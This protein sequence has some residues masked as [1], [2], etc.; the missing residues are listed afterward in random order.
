MSDT[1][2]TGTFCWNELVTG[3]TEKAGEFYSKLLGWECVERDMGQFV[4][5][6]F[7]MGDTFAGGMMAIQKE[8]GEV[9]P[10]WMSYIL[11]DD[12]DAST[13][14]AEELGAKMCVTPMDIPNVGRFSTIIDPTGAAVS[15]FAPK[16]K[17]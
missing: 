6:E 8:W 10:H 13:K 16:K 4:Y 9:S 2:K 11:V 1:P 5:T 14:K 3:D 17:D 12:V 15:F 7:K